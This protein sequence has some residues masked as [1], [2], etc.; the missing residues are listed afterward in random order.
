[1]RITDISTILLTV[2]VGEMR[3]SGGEASAVPATLIQVHTDEGLT[4]LGDV[5]CGALVPGAVPPLVEHFRGHLLGMDP[6]QIPQA[7]KTMHG[8]SLFWGRAG[9]PVAVMS[10]IE[11]ALWDIAGKAAGLPVYRL[12]GGLAHESLPIYASGGLDKA[13]DA[14]IAEL[15]EYQQAG[16]RAVKIR[17]GH[18]VRRDCERVRLAREVLGP[19]IEIM[20]DAVQGHNPEPWP[21][22]TAIAVAESIEDYGISWFEEPCLA[23]DPDSYARVRSATR[24]PIAGGESCTSMQEFRAFFEADALDIVQPDVSHAGGIL[25]CRAL[26][27]V[28]EMYGVRLAPHSWGTGAMLAATYHFAFATSNCHILEYPTWGHPLRDELL[29][30]PFDI[31]EGS[32]YPQDV[33][34]LGVELRKETI[35]KYP[36]LAGAQLTIRRTTG[37]AH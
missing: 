10:A 1:M 19:D 21:A 3:W 8:R 4:G 14:F 7:W 18:G 22:S 37:A 13:A 31:R 33:P 5:Y 32:M 34:G 28:A 24:I 12:L 11:N 9:L 6:L 23:S 27:A 29:V 30:N 16:L 17:I 25:G 35:E 26:A 15:R 2:P 36:Y 20:V